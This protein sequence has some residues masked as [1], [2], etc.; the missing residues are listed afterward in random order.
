MGYDP[1]KRPAACQG[2]PFP[3]AVA[4]APEPFPPPSIAKWLGR[5]AVSKDDLITELR[6]WA[7][8]FE[9]AEPVPD[10]AQQER[11]AYIQELDGGVE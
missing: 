10:L 6:A 4:E 7:N 1:A 2:S 9:R 3:V 8:F 11:E 5:S